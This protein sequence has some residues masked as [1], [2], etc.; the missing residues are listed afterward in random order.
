MKYVIPKSLL[1]SR[2]DRFG[3]TAHVAATCGDGGDFRET[4]FDTSEYVCQT[5][6]A[7][8]ANP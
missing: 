5:L 7:I 1:E 3:I 2:A 4:F 6:T 8:T